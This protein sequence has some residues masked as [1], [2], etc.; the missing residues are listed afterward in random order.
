MHGVADRMHGLFKD[1]N[2]ILLAELANEHQYFLASHS[3]FLPCGYIYF[4]SR[5]NVPYPKGRTVKGKAQI[6]KLV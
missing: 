5:N 6:A 2:L 4:G 1:E 3:R